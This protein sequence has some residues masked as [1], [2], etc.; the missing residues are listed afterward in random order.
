MLD[1]AETGQPGLLSLT[2]SVHP[3]EIP[4][5]E[6][7]NSFSWQMGL[8]LTGQPIANGSLEFI[9]E[10]GL[11]DV[12]ADY[13]LTAQRCETQWTGHSGP[14]GELSCPSMVTTLLVDEPL[15]AGPTA[16]IPFGDVSAS[17]SPH[18]LF[19]LSVPEEAAVAGPFTFALG[20]T[21]M[22]DESAT[23]GSLPATGSAI[24]GALAAGT[25]LLGAGLLAKL[26][27]RRAGRP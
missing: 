6:A 10:G 7:G 17:G 4:W 23:P 19:T 15:Q 27:Y 11:I 13:R 26:G 14:G 21:V 18:V 25:I 3:L 1:V 12:T 24:A 5:L 16:S 9:P 20:F 2:S 8:N 22:G